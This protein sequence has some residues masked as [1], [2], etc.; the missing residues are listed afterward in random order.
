MKFLKIITIIVLSMILS[1]CIL[2]ISSVLLISHIIEKNKEKRE[3]QKEQEIEEYFDLV[4]GIFEK[5]Y[6]LSMDK[7]KYEVE[8][9]NLLRGGVILSPNSYIMKKRGWVT[10]KSKYLYTNEPEYENVLI[11]ENGANGAFLKEKNPDEYHKKERLSLLLAVMDRLGFRKYVLNELLYDK[12][13]GN[14]FRE[15]E[16]IFDSYKDVKIFRR[17]DKWYND[18]TTYLEELLFYNQ[19]GEIFGNSSNTFL[20]YK[21]IVQKKDSDKFLEEYG[22]RLEK[23]FSKKRKF[24]EIDWEDFKKYNE[25]RPIVEFWFEN[26][27]EEELEKIRKKIK[28]YYNEEEV[29]IKL[30]IYTPPES[31]YDGGK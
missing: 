30:S 28:P 20:F 17:G 16:K 11:V 18:Y 10:Y 29:L 15:I 4:T 25:L 3:M 1:S 19:D 21:K 14:D 24:E 12:S 8:Y 22:K 9:V 5:D 7:E 2:T 31:Q 26:I 13:K 6:N 23:Y 27:T